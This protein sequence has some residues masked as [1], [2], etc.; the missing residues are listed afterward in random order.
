MRV[1]ATNVKMS[2]VPGLVGLLAEI[3]DANAKIAT[4]CRDNMDGDFARFADGVAT[5]LAHKK[6][7]ELDDPVKRDAFYY[8]LM[9]TKGFFNISQTVFEAVFKGIVMRRKAV[10]VLGQTLLDLTLEVSFGKLQK[11]GMKE[12]KGEYE[13]AMKQN[14]KDLHQEYVTQAMKGFE[15]KVSEVLQAAVDMVAKAQTELAGKLQSLAKATQ[16][17]DGHLEYILEKNPGRSGNPGEICEKLGR[18]LRPYDE[19]SG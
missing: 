16:K 17:A 13:E 11:K 9:N 10:D 7:A 12:S 2:L 14:V 8:R 6:Q 3:R 5:L 15:K 18:R 1:D 4:R 19:A